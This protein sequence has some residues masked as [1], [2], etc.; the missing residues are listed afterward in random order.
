MS[1]RRQQALHHRLIH[2]VEVAMGDEEPSRRGA[3]EM[4]LVTLVEQCLDRGADEPIYRA[5]SELKRQGRNPAADYLFAWAETATEVLSGQWL[6]SDGEVER[7]TFNLFW[8]PLVLA[9]DRPLADPTLR[10]SGV[11]R[12]QQALRRHQLIGP[13]VGAWVWP[14][15]WRLDE[16]PGGLAERRQWL[17]RLAAVASAQASN[18][19]EPP[20][21][22]ELP[23]ASEALISLHFLA[24]ILAV[25]EDDLDPGPLAD[26]R[27]SNTTGEAS[28]Q[29][30]QAFDRW[31]QAAAGFLP[32]AIAGV[33]LLWVAMPAP[34]DEAILHGTEL[35]NSVLLSHALLALGPEARPVAALAGY[36]QEP[37]EWR[38]GLRDVQG[39]FTWSSWFCLEEPRVEED[40]IRSLLAAEG[41][42]VA[43]T[44]AA[45]GRD[46]RC[47]KCTGPQ[48][49]DPTGDPGTFLP[50]LC[51]EPASP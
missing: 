8:L 17:H 32:A 14:R 3:A 21:A 30:W 47:P 48:F 22:P 4:E 19:P 38:I 40:K 36:G 39:Q 49:P 23:S 18:L 29:E 1:S 5:V 35:M 15:L 43:Y 46:A 37:S 16:L 27:F 44:I 34:W 13:R 50:C 33:S 41:I 10:P 9:Q 2:L 24:L 42:P 51:T 31:Q 25:R 12:L 28:A 6:G 26:D 11:R 45:F 7:G 20:G